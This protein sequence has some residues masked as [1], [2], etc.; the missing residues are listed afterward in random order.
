[1]QTGV[2]GPQLLGGI[3]RDIK[4]MGFA[5]FWLSSLSLF[6]FSIGTLL[7][8]GLAQAGFFL[9]SSVM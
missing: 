6:R 8:A 9:P 3:I 7:R 2:R 1:M 4:G 5:F